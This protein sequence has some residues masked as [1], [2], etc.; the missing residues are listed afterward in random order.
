MGGH[1]KGDPRLATHRKARILT[2]TQ[3]VIGAPR[4]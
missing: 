4:A 3:F 2:E 1:G